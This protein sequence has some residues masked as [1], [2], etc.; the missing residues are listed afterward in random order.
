MQ[1]PESIKKNNL[2]TASLKSVI[3]EFL[4]PNYW[5]LS[6]DKISTCSVCEFRYLCNDCRPLANA[7]TTRANN[8]NY[9]P[10]SGE[11]L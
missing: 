9:D 5:E 11:W 6:K 7:L 1:S 3:D 10:F 4:I 8:C 2:K